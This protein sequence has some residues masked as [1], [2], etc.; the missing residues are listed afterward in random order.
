MKV[1]GP[2]TGQ[3]FIN[4]TGQHI[5]QRVPP[6]EKKGRRQTSV[7]CVAVLPIPSETELKSLPES[8]LEITATKGTGPGGQHKNKS[9]TCIRAKHKPTGIEVVID[10]RSQQQSKRQAIRILTARVAEQKLQ[11]ER[12]EF[13]DNRKAQLGDGNRGGKIRTYNF[14]NSQVTNHR[15]GKK[16]GNIKEVMKGNLGLIL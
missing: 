13:S 16:T 7:I 11:K 4:E 5:V 12:N 8:E 3:A 10:E 2:G 1:W 9:H 14:I 15:T 6:T